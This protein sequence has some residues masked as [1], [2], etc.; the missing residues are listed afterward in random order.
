[1]RTLSDIPDWV[2]TETFGN[3]VFDFKNSSVNKEEYDE[4]INKSPIRYVDNVKTPVL[5]LLG[6]VDLRVPASQGK[7]YYKALISRNKSARL[8]IYKDDNHPLSKP[9]TTADCIVNAILWF[10]KYLI[11]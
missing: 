1:M 3:Y 5:I 8:V 11:D 2:I 7:E 9:Q 6:S 10:E 4:L